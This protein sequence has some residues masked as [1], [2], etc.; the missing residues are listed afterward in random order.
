MIVALKKS[1]K[2]KT[3]SKDKFP[4]EIY[5]IVEVD[6]K[7]E[8]N[9]SKAILTLFNRWLDESFSPEQWTEN[10]VVFLGS[11]VLPFMA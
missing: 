5:K 6:K 10:L 3:A 7:C 9:M 11:A 2:G 4:C 8:P 1:Q